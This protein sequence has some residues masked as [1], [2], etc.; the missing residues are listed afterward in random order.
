MVS[1]AVGFCVCVFLFFCFVGIVTFCFLVNMMKICSWGGEEFGLMGSVE[2]VEQYSKILSERAVV[3]LNFDISVGGNFVMHSSSS[4]LMKNDIWKHIKEINDPN[5]HDGK[6]SIYDIMVERYPSKTDPGK[7]KIGTLGSGSDYASFYQ[8]VGVPSADF[9]Y[10]FGHNDKSLFYPVYHS[11]HDT[12]NWMKKFVDPEFKFHKA[13]AQLS[14]A[15]LLYYTDSPLLSMSVSQY[16][17]IL[18]KSL[19][20]LKANENLEGRDDISLDVLEDAIDT[21]YRVSE[22]FNE[23]R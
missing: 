6:N 23:V 5:A 8:Y 11:Q 16:S 18:N 10:Y 14:G 17:D 19:T 7:P 1:F 4:P 12:F 22:K 9:S 2:W 3:Y 13:M 15:L 21:F 20:T